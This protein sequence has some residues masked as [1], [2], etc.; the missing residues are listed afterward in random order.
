MEK[1]LED[2]QKAYGQ[3]FTPDGLPE[4]API[5]FSELEK[6]A[7]SKPRQPRFVNVTSTEKYDGQPRFEGGISWNQGGLPGL[8]KRR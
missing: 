1:N 8:G 6:Q 3:G 7:K 4:L 5:G 2:R